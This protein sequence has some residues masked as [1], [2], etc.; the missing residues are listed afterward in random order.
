MDLRHRDLSWPLKASF[1]PE[2]RPRS[3]RKQI[4]Q[5]RRHMLF[6]CKTIREPSTARR[7]NLTAYELCGNQDGSDFIDTNSYGVSRS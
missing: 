3:F 5:S 1:Y 7:M 4:V 6:E 2:S